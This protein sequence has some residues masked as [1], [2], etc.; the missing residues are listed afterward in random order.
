MGGA[1]A[2]TSTTVHDKSVRGAYYRVATSAEHKKAASQ[3]HSTIDFYPVLSFKAAAMPIP[4]IQL[5]LVMAVASVIFTA[6]AAPGTP[7]GTVGGPATV[8]LGSVASCIIPTAGK[9]CVLHLCMPLT[10]VQINVE[11]TGGP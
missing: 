11:A 10:N 9:S 4:K 8:C 3:L 7:T 5:A 1:T 6:S 2:C